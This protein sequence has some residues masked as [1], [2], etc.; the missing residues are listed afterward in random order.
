MS[1]NFNPG[2]MVYLEVP[3]DSLK[4]SSLLYSGS[5]WEKYLL[6][7]LLNSGTPLNFNFFSPS[8][9][10]AYLPATTLHDQNPRSH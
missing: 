9:S 3:A 7:S 6:D 2:F 8:S 4:D 10:F 5:P 1:R